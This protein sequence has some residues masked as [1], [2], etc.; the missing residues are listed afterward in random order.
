MLAAELPVNVAEIFGDLDGVFD[1]VSLTNSNTVPS[2]QASQRRST[3][4]L[5]PTK[6]ALMRRGRASGER[7]AASSCGFDRADR[8]RRELTAASLNR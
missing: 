6:V 8:L 2:L 3:F 7:P 4:N 5:I 1:R